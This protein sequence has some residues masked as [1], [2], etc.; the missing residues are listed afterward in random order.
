M[1]VDDN[2]FNESTIFQ[3]EMGE[4]GTMVYLRTLIHEDM[5]HMPFPGD[6]PSTTALEAQERILWAL[7]QCVINIE[8]VKDSLKSTSS[9]KKTSEA[10]LLILYQC[11]VS[12]NPAID[13]TLWNYM[14]RQKGLYNDLFG[15]TPS[16]LASPS[17]IIRSTIMKLIQD[18]STDIDLEFDPND[19]LPDIMP[20]PWGPPLSSP[21]KKP[22]SDPEIERKEQP[23]FD[24]RKVLDLEKFLN[25]NLIGQY[26]AVNEIVKTLK[27]STAGLKDDRRPLGV[28]LFA[29]SSGTGKT[30]TA[31][32]LQEH[33]FGKETRIV[34]VDCSEYQ[35]KHD[36][37]KLLGSPNS[38]VGY[39]DGGQLTN[40]IKESQ[41][42]VLLLDE[43]E[44]AHRDFWDIFL[45]VFDEGY[46]TDNKGENISF[47]NTIII[48]TSN[49]GNEK[50]AH[51]AYGKSTGFTARIT[52]DYSSGIPPARSYI[53][54]ETKSAINKFFKPEF[55]NRLD[56]IVIFNYLSEE[57]LEKI[58][59]L[60][61]EHVNKKIQNQG[62]KLQWTKTAEKALAAKSLKA[63][64]GA[65]AMSKIRR[66]EIEDPLAEIILT[67][68]PPRG[69]NFH[70]SARKKNDEYIFII[71]KNKQT[72]I[73]ESVKNERT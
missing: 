60:E 23:S 21:G 63:I 19:F 48:M 68:Y 66:K 4:V 7:N 62:Y 12:I 16:E 55:V 33:L 43:A 17:D 53:E 72:P 40:A 57:N 5:A 15:V 58:A 20:P 61:F 6:L 38:Y 70:L 59:R 2:D 37:M 29:G 41:N 45:K 28:F 3:V 44:K 56:E 65:R 22:K 42:T 64:Q 1:I 10:V 52:D 13:M 27:R 8:E 49:L 31:K 25:D 34:R 11:C 67:E 35:Q 46:L 50:I 26:E 69:T 71:N 47:E 39:E 36:S 32:L 54:K 30:H 51:E 9:D 24:K 14:V 18:D 73:K